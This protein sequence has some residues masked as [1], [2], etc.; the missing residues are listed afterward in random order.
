[1]AT[2]AQ[3][4]CSVALLNSLLIDLFRTL[5]YVIPGELALYPG[6]TGPGQ[7]F[8]LFR[9]ADNPVYA[10]GYGLGLDIS[11]Q[12]ILEVVDYAHRIS[13]HYRLAGI[14][15]LQHDHSKWL[16]ARGNAHHIAGIDQHLLLRTGCVPQEPAGICD[17]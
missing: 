7:V 16:I 9:I 5:S 6:P 13:G 15:C 12:P 4:F 8:H 17:A 1:M 11:Q 10:P 14:L 2:L 3:R